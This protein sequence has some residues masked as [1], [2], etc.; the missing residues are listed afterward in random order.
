MDPQLRIDALNTITPNLA[1][2]MVDLPPSQLSID[3]LNGTTQNL[4]DLLPQRVFYAKDLF[5]TRVTISFKLCANA[6]SLFSL[7]IGTHYS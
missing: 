1:H 3:A 4:A 6:Y 7:L 2:L 5:P